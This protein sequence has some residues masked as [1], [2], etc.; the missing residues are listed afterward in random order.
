MQADQDTSTAQLLKTLTRTQDSDTP[1]LLHQ[2]Q[3]PYQQPH[4]ASYC[5]QQHTR[6][7]LLHLTIA[8]MSSRVNCLRPIWGCRM[9][10][11]TCCEK[12][13]TPQTSG[14]RSCYCC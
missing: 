10:R 4:A 11:C 3:H 5:S 14:T 2:Q 7:Q 8:R 1:T 13:G 12:A 6:S 9:D